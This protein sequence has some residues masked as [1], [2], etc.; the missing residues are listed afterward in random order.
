M[1]NIFAKSFKQQHL[2]HMRVEEQHLH[3]GS[4]C[5]KPD[6]KIYFSE[7]RSFLILFYPYM[8][9]TKYNDC[10][11]LSNSVANSQAPAGQHARITFDPYPYK[12]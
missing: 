10:T 3:I 5:R 1:T 7:D 12:I 2:K 4:H 9:H 6:V 11:G 8:W